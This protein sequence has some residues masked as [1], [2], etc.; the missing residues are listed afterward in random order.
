MSKDKTA[1]MDANLS[2]ALKFAEGTRVWLQAANAG[3]DPVNALLLLP[4][5]EHAGNLER[6]IAALCEA[7]TQARG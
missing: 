5:I 2:Q 4:M 3:A 7:R 6:A 1:T